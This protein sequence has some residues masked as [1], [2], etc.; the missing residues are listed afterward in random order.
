MTSTSLMRSIHRIFLK[1]W[2][3]L[4]SRDYGDQ[5]RGDFSRNDYVSSKTGIEEFAM[6]LR[7]KVL[8]GLGAAFGLALIAIVL[9]TQGIVIGGFQKLENRYSV[10][11]VNRVGAAM[12]NELS[13]LVIF[14]KDWGR[15]DDTRDFIL[16]KK[17]EYVTQNLSDSSVVTLQVNVM[18]FWGNDGR[19]V[20]VKGVD[21]NEKTDWT[22]PDGIVGAISK[23]KELFTFKEA[24]D[25]MSGVLQTEI[26]PILLAATPVTNNDN[27]LPIHGTLIV[28][29]LFDA[30][31]V[32]KLAQQ[33]QLD[34][35]LLKRSEMNKEG[36]DGAVGELSESNPVVIHM[37]D[38][39]TIH[40]YHLVSDLAGNN[41]LVLQVSMPR[42]ILQEGKS[43]VLYFLG[44]LGWIVTLI[45]ITLWIVLRYS[46]LNPVHRLAFHVAKIIQTGD[47]TERLETGSRDEL[48]M[49]TRQFNNLTEQL[50]QARK[51]LTDQAFQSG[52]S[53][54]ASGVLHNLRNALTPITTEI[55]GLCREVDTVPLSHLQQAI[56]EMAQPVT[57][58]SRREKLIRF[59]DSGRDNLIGLVGRIH[60]RLEGINRPMAQVDQILADQQRF[61]SKSVSSE[62]VRPQELLTDAITLVGKEI[63]QDIEV[64]VDPSVSSLEPIEMARIPMVQVVSNLL[65]NAAESIRLSGRTGGKITLDAS[66]LCGDSG[67]IF[68]LQVRDNGGGFGPEVQER[69]FER[70]FSTK[71]KTN[72][73]L[74]LHWS[75]NV[76]NTLCGHIRGQSDGPGQGALFTVEFPILNPLRKG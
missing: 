14:V 32:E 48:G 25:S 47:L 27:T 75:A 71:G 67:Q 37:Q 28:G 46:V 19:C 52:M 64:R 58:P 21:L 2:M 35:T 69:L 7:K 11:N 39:K 15:W 5:V 57:D 24:T 36:D 51:Q 31:V 17:P 50:H 54:M 33:T 9:L 20:A 76:L 4:Y 61:C 65:I 68:R 45:G 38:S 22:V 73:G 56:A 62:A 49:L 59:V 3:G 74:G 10:T 16:G 42:D 63:L 34:L 53:E 40:G 44:S 6:S 23:R 43:S 1:V 30:S 66:I 41:D 29:R 60:E 72:S 70:G 8:L 26:G 13:R 55:E 12:N 18:T